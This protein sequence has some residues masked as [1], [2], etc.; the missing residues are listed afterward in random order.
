MTGAS[1]IRIGRRRD[2]RGGR[3]AFRHHR[4]GRL[5]R[6]TELVDLDGRRFGGKIEGL[7]RHRT[8]PE[9]V[10]FVIDDGDEDLQSVLYAAELLEGKAD[11]DLDPAPVDK[12][13]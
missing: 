8:Y 2:R 1:S 5:A 9:R 13:G 6:W 7:S 12:T 4:A 10:R 11:M 3:L